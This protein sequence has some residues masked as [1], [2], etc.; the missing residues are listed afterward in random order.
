MQTFLGTEISDFDGQFSADIEAFATPPV[1]GSHVTA[2]SRIRRRIVTTSNYGEDKVFRNFVHGPDTWWESG[3]LAW[4]SNPARSEGFLLQGGWTGG[5]WA[6][7]TAECRF[8]LGYGIRIGM[9][10]GWWY[11]PG[12]D[13]ATWMALPYADWDSPKRSWF[14][15][16]D[17]GR[18]FRGDLSQRIRIGRRWGRIEAY[19]GAL[20]EYE[21]GEVL[22]EGRLQFDLG[23][24]GVEPGLVVPDLAPCPQGGPYDAYA[25]RDGRQRIQLAPSRLGLHPHVAHEAARLSSIVDGTHTPHPWN[26]D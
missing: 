10:S 23:W 1:L 8:P 20:R 17:G 2:A 18:F 11:S 9:T 26:L 14:V 16:A 13:T 15:R 21:H 4:V 24:L 19:L 5:D 25:H 3:A 7:P 22:A 12:W 6:G